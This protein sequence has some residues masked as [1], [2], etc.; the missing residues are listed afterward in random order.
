MSNL[1]DQHYEALALAQLDSQSD[2]SSNKRLA[3]TVLSDD[4][5]AKLALAW[6][7]SYVGKLSSIAESNIP[8]PTGLPESYW[9]RW[10]WACYSI[11]YADWLL[12]AGLPAAD[13]YLAKAKALK[14]RG[15]VFPNGEIHQ[16]VEKMLFTAVAKSAKLKG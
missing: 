8:I 13:V 5:S 10:V 1:H 2:T 12:A 16:W 6:A 15:V 7:E 9:L 3:A 14:E 4:A 11:N